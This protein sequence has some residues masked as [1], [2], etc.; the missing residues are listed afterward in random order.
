MAQ[1]GDTRFNNI[2]AN[3][4]A[5]FRC[6]PDIGR[7]MNSTTQSTRPLTRATKTQETWPAGVLSAQAA[8]SVASTKAK[9]PIVSAIPAPQILLSCCT[10]VYNSKAGDW[11]SAVGSVFQPPS[12]GPGMSAGGCSENQYPAV[13]DAVG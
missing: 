12:V 8:A 11:V 1:A 10:P 2:A 5:G 6:A 4:T 9:V 3:V 13:H 7:K